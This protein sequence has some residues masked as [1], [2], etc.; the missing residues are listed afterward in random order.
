MIPVSY[1]APLWKFF[2]LLHRLKRLIVDASVS[3]FKR[4]IM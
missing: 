1:T 2:V 4:T 3:A